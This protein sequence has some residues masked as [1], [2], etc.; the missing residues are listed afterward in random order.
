M[1]KNWRPLVSLVQISGGRVA[2]FIDTF[3]KTTGE[4]TVPSE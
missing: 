1:W 2:E 3:E 4:G